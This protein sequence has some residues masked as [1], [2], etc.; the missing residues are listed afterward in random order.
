MRT[1]RNGLIGK[2]KVGITFTCTLILGSGVMINHKSLNSY[3]YYLLL[4]KH[5]IQIN[6]HAHESTSLN[7]NYPG[8]EIYTF[9]CMQ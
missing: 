1:H 5:G 6:F 9:T 3:I 4:P 2:P 7:N 8:A